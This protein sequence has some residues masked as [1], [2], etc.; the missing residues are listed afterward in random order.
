MSESVFTPTGE[1]VD[2]RSG[3]AVKHRLAEEV[4]PPTGCS[5]IEQTGECSYRQ[6]RQSANRRFDTTGLNIS[7]GTIDSER[8]QNA[9]CDFERSR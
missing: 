3:K 7:A 6:I 9:A 2:Q 5:V 4:K 1:A 8:S